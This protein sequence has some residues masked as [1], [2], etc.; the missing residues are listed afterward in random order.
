M[1][2]MLEEHLDEATDTTAVLAALDEATGRF[3]AMLRSL[4]PEEASRPVAGSDWTVAQ[5]AAHVC[6]LFRRTTSDDRRAADRDDL[7]RL[8]DE[9]I[10]EVGG[11]VTAIADEIAQLHEVVV[12]FAPHIPADRAFPFH[13]GVPVT[14]A[15]GLAVIVGELE[16]HGSEVAT[17]AHRPWHIDPEHL[18]LVWRHAAPVL[19]G[20]LRPE[21]GDID[22]AWAF[23]FPEA[24][25]PVVVRLAHGRVTVGAPDGRPIDHTVDVADTIELTLGFP[26]GRRPLVSPAVARL[27]TLFHPT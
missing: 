24:R 2:Y 26:Y 27:T 13:C 5:T 16:V 4:S 9:G 6:S 19:Q 20:W 1:Q 3:V 21:A 8:N 23:A 25:E 7:V 17:A 14:M 12:Q 15:G 10:D 22:E 11:D 18:L